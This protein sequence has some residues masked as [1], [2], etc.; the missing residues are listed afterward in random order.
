[1]PATVVFTEFMLE[2]KAEG[3]GGGLVPS[4]PDIK[5]WLPYIIG[6]PI[7]AGVGLGYAGSRLT[8]PNDDDA[9]ALQKEL[10]LSKYER[11]VA[12]RQREAE[13]ESSMSKLQSAPVKKIDPF[14]M[15]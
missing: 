14:L 9:K 1:M 11:E 6:A 2:K 12:K 13:V 15:V 10:L 5:S 8:S 4:V 7:V 3:H